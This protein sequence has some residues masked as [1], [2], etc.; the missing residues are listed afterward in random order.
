MSNLGGGGEIQAD[1]ADHTR[2]TH[3]DQR[4]VL[5]SPQHVDYQKDSKWKIGNLFHKSRPKTAKSKPTG[6]RSTA[7]NHEE[8]DQNGSST[9]HRGEVL[10]LSNLINADLMSV[11]NTRQQ[12]STYEVSINKLCEKF[13]GLNERGSVEEFRELKKAVRKLKQQISSGH[14]DEDPDSETNQS[15][16][17]NITADVDRAKADKVAHQMPDLNKNP[18]FERSSEFKDF[19]ARYLELKEELRLCLLCFAVFPENEKIKKK[20]MV[21]W[22]IGEG[23]VPPVEREITE[24]DKTAEQF[25]S[26][27]FDELVAKGFVEPIYR[28]RSGKVETCKMH[29]LVRSMVIRLAKRANFFDF[30]DDFNAKEDC[31]L[32]LRACL[33]SKGLTKDQETKMFEDLEKLHTM[34]NVNQT[35]LDFDPEWLAKMKNI[36]VL[37]LGRWQT[38]A[39]HHIEVE[40]TK[41][42]KKKDAHVLDGLENMK[43]LRFLSLQGV[44]RITDLPKAISELTNLTI[45]DLRACHNLEVIP[46]EIGCLK[47]L[48]HLDMSECYLLDRMPKELSSLTELRVLSGFV[49]GDS[50]SRNSCTLDELKSLSNLRKLSIHTGTDQFP[51]EGDLRAF[52]QFRAL[53]KLT[54]V[55]GRGSVQAKSDDPRSQAPARENKD[56][57]NKDVSEAEQPATKSKRS[58][59]QTVQAESS[60]SNQGAG[61]PSRENSEDKE[62]SGMAEEVAT[63]AHH[64]DLQK[65][66]PRS[67]GSKQVKWAQN[68][69]NERDGKR[70]ADSTTEPASGRSSTMAT[71]PAKENK[72]NDKKKGITEAEQPT[73]AANRSGLQGVQAEPS[74]SNQG[75]GTPSSEIREDG[76]AN[77]PAVRTTRRSRFKRASNS[78]ARTFSSPRAAQPEG[79][80]L[81]PSGLIKLDLQCFPLM[82]APDWLRPGKLKNLEKLF[83][84]GGKFGDLGQFQ[85]FDGEHVLNPEDRKWKVE[86]LR[87]KYLTELEMDWR[88]LQELFPNLE[89]LEKVDCP[90]LSLCPCDDSGVWMKKKRL[91]T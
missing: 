71:I 85:E 26:K 63:A 38:E 12:V 82:I 49:L 35:I 66:V 48:T 54:I 3:S 17:S 33:T 51:S 60:P 67:R 44:S 1:P 86:E 47:K 19:Q 87:L 21:Y 32:S 91:T 37:Y 61:T 5:N 69:K 65:T 62:D 16:K 78:L 64:S 58:D 29:P 77:S 27:Y 59:L 11:K 28:K 53:T 84:R 39:T 4:S 50:K 13:E 68:S 22:W 23:F 8:A 45:L 24:K 72:E 7:N 55:W 41:T 31:T 46:D 70:K 10:A 89:Y 88:E 52:N 36:N 76:K 18:N 81:L 9:R 25:G 73:A 57:K 15:L 20:T 34:F 42:L 43:H 80:P 75:V 79:Q 74:A 83:I 30:D 40:D 6:D 56:D 14:K 90:Q 2:G